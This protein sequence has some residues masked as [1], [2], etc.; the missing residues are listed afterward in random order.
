MVAVFGPAI[1]LL[2]LPGL[3]L[4]TLAALLANLVGSWF[5]LWPL[6]VPIVS[7]WVFGFL[8]LC[9]IASDIVDW[10]AGIVGAR[11]MGGTRGAMFAAFIGGI[12]GAIVGTGVL[13]IIGTLIGGAIGAGLAATLVHRTAPEQTWKRSAKVGAGASAGWFVAIIVKFVLATICAVTLISS[14]WFSW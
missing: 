7:W 11:R 9:T 2:S 1:V 14:A 13:P 4:M 8:L 3:W 10:T 6:E 12:A 5:G